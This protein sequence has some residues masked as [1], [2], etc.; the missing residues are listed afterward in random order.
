MTRYQVDERAQ[1]VAR[2]LV[3]AGA[4]CVNLVGGAV[5]DLV[6]GRD[7]KDL[8]LEVFGIT[9]A[10]AE[11]ALATFGPV[12]AVGRSFGVFKVSVDGMDFDVSL[13]RRDNKIAEGH[14][15]FEVTVDDGMTIAEAAARRDFT[16][17]AMAVDVLT[18][19][20][21]DPFQGRADI[22]AGILRH[23]S[24]HFA[25][26]PLRVLRAMQF[27]ARFDMVLAPETAMLCRALVAEA[28]SLPMERVWGE[29]EKMLVK[30]Q[31][32]AAGLRVLQDSGWLAVFPELHALVGLAQNPE[33]HPE[34]SVFNHVLAAVRHV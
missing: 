8:D 24:E 15:G 11:Q 7:P 33:W 32:V 30:G 20:L 9:P 13:P 16:M 25:E 6:Q 5:R 31:N 26:D 34:G 21:H 12:N 18:G 29:W 2:V 4:R 1:R 14:K 19:E 17:N 3:G 10:R 27:A 22:E 23:T 28:A